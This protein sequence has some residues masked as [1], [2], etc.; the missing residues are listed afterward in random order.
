[1]KD[2]MSHVPQA[3]VEQIT[4]DQLDALIAGKLFTIID[5]RSPEAIESQGEI[6]T[7]INIPLDTMD[8]V[9]EEDS[10]DKHEVFYSDRP[11]LFC[12]TGGVMSYVAALKASNKGI[13]QLHNLEGGHSAWKKLREAKATS[14]AA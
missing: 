7:A 4:A 11:L 3:P 6:P 2:I 10:N 5:V 12:C 14:E 9:L 13:G 8:Q 1:M